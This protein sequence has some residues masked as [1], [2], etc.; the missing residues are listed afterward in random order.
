VLAVHGV[1]A[2]DYSNED[3]GMSKTFNQDQCS[4]QET[5]SYIVADSLASI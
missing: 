4:K 2:Y 1:S 3:S 5:S